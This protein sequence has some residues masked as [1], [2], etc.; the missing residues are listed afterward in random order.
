M[1]IHD[2][3]LSYSQIFYP[4]AMGLQSFMKKDP[5]I[6]S[7]IF[8]LQKTAEI[9]QI[10]PTNMSFDQNVMALNLKDLRK[11]GYLL[12]QKCLYFTHTYPHNKFGELID[13]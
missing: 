8:Y 6:R 4:I 3:D 10:N 2:F 5:F 9:K 7:W 12:I 13:I 11:F 1:F